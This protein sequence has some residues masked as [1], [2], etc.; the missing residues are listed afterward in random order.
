MKTIS[1]NKEAL[2]G[3]FIIALIMLVSIAHGKGTYSH[4]VIKHIGNK[5]Y[6]YDYAGFRTPSNKH[7]KVLKRF[8]KPIIKHFK[9]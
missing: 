5:K 4:N 3:L 7:T 2:I 6:S 1:Q 8:Y 9:R